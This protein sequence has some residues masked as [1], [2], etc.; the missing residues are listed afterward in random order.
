MGRRR[1]HPH[2]R[3]MEGKRSHSTPINTNIPKPPSSRPP[4]PAW[5]Q[6]EA[7]KAWKYLCEQLEKMGIIGTSDQAIMVVYCQQWEI[8][9]LAT[10]RMLEIA[11]ERDRKAAEAAERAGKEQ[12][13]A[14]TESGDW[15]D[16]MLATTS[17]GNVVN[18]PLLGIANAAWERVV[19][20]ASLLGLHPTDRAKLVLQAPKGKTLREELL[21]D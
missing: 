18:N 17:N 19:R 9:V 4:C 12:L 21:E 2:L 6:P 8:A 13:P 20:C 16:A 11:A 3:L 14:R 10:R 5:L 15:T 1:K 7:R